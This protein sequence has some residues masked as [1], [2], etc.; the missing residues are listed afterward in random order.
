MTT[1]ELNESANKLNLFTEERKV[2]DYRKIKSRILL[3]CFLAMMLQM[4]GTS[5]AGIRHITASQA[6]VPEKPVVSAGAQLI[7]VSGEPQTRIAHRYSLLQEA[8][9]L[10]VE[11]QGMIDQGAKTAIHIRQEKVQRSIRELR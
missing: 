8:R 11:E 6:L 7:S 1:D 3:F 9:L 10:R 4:T 5:A 2:K